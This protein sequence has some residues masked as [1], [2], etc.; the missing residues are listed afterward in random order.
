VHD[1]VLL[2]FP[3][4]E[5]FDSR[6]QRASEIMAERFSHRVPGV[7]TSIKAGAFAE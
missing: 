4:D 3:D 5:H 1:A 6:V 7:S 2:Q